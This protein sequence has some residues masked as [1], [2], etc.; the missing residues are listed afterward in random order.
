MELSKLILDFVKVLIWPVTTIG[1]V[2]IF[3]SQLVALLSRLRK[4]DLPGGVSIN[5]EKQIQ[6]VKQLSEKVGA[7]PTP[8]DRPKPPAIPLTEANARM[9]SLELRPS[10]SGLDMTYYRDIALNDPTLALAGLRIELEIMAKNLARGFKI[11]IR[12]TE[13]IGRLLSRLKAEGS[14][15]NEQL[16]LTRKI[17]DVCN[18]AVHGR[19][20]TKEEAEEVIT[21][22]EV[23]TQ[24]YLNWLSWGFPDNWTPR[25]N[26]SR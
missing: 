19:T 7:L 24:Q 5:F 6:E 14:I 21:A 20:V 3:R 26:A 16:Q 12:E 2:L 15:T 8:T 13:S 18:Q 23:L 1:L 22:A 17:L 4:A 25:G 10:P 9:I 11:P